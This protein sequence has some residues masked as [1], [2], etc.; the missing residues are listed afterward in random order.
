MIMKAI[1]LP[2]GVFSLLALITE[3]FYTSADVTVIFS[4]F[5]STFLQDKQDRTTKIIIRILKDNIL[6]IHLGRHVNPLTLI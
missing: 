5:S 1:D 6:V 2:R 3:P 4:H